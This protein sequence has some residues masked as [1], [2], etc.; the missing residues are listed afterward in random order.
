MQAFLIKNYRVLFIVLLGALVGS[1]FYVGMLE[2]EQ[3]Q[4]DHVTLSCSDDILKN[5]AI[6][7]DTKAQGIVNPPSTE[8]VGATTLPQGA[9]AG[10][11]NGTK[12][13]APGC[14]AL[15]RIKPENII[16]FQN[17]EDARLQGYTA[18]QC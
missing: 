7:L 12:Y 2:G 15:D 17:E 6:P 9:Y 8:P 18:A 5:L 11:K 13:Y 14:P 1:S 3:H 16:W 10:S 4:S